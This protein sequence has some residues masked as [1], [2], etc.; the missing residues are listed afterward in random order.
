MRNHKIEI[1]QTKCGNHKKTREIKP[2]KSENQL[3]THKANKHSVNAFNSFSVF[4]F[5][6]FNISFLLNM[7]SIFIWKIVAEVFL[8]KTM[9][10]SYAG[11]QTKLWQRQKQQK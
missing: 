3:E 9:G 2:N 6:I 7:G 1:L 4:I 5:S 8:G 11:A 10:E